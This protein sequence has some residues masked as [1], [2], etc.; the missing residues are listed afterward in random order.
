[1]SKQKRKIGRPKDR[2][3]ENLKIEGNGEEPHGDRRTYH[4]QRDQ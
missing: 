3:S 1:M 4:F 2:K